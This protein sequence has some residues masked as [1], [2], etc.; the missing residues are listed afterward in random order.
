MQASTVRKIGK[1]ITVVFEPNLG[2]H[3]TAVRNCSAILI[4]VWNRPKP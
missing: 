3:Q 1:L 4:F 2:R